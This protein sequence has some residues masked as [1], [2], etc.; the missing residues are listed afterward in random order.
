[1]TTGRAHKR[2][3]ISVIDGLIT[4]TGPGGLIAGMLRWRTKAHGKYSGSSIVPFV[5]GRCHFKD[6]PIF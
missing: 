6:T 3:E 5:N 4:R 1:M 2:K